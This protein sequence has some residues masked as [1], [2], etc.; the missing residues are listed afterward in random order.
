MRVAQA[1]IMVIKYVEL[2][3]AQIVL[4]MSNM[5]KKM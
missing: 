1:D 5:F 3:Q 2:I 4:N